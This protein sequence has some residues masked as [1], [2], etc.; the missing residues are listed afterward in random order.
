VVEDIASKAGFGLLR[1]WHNACLFKHPGCPSLSLFSPP[2]LPTRVIDV[3]P[4]ELPPE[5]RLY[6]AKAADRNCRYAI[7]SHCWGPDASNISKT[8][9]TNLEVLHDR[10][11]LST[12]SRNF[13]DAI[14]IAHGMK[15]RF[16][17][18]DA[19]CIIQDSPEDWARESAKMA[20]YYKNADITIA[21]LASPHASHGLLNPRYSDRNVA[22]I[23]TPCG[24][25]FVRPQL[26]DTVS[27]VSN[28]SYSV[29]RP[30]V[31]YM[32]LN[33]RAWT[34]Q[35]RVLSSRIIHFSEQQLV[36]Q[37]KTCA[38]SEDGQYTE[39][40]K[41]ASK[42]KL[43]DLLDLKINR[44]PTHPE[45]LISIIRTGWH[46]LLAEYTSPHLTYDSDKLPALSGLAHE[47]SKLTEDNY[48][49]GL[50][51][52]RL[53]EELLWRRLGDDDQR[54][55]IVPS[56]IHNG[57]PTWSWAS[58]KG[59]IR[60]EVVR[61][62]R[63][64]HEYD[65]RIVKTYSKLATSDPFG[66]VLSANVSISIMCHD[67]VGPTTFAKKSAHAAPSPPR[68]GS[69]SSAEDNTSTY[70]PSE[71]Q[72][73]TFATVRLDVNEPKCDFTATPHLIACFGEYNSDGGSTDPTWADPKNKHSHQEF[74][75]LQRKGKVAGTVYCRVG[76]AS[77]MDGTRRK[78]RIMEEEGWMRRTILIM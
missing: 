74:M 42:R 47:V 19:L 64:P 71:Y 2:E 20:Q 43:V 45:A 32:P 10:I 68:S 62:R 54:D 49:A 24:E 75:L 27:I 67:Y 61:Y 56:R 21:G 18:I 70:F 38:V 69:E 77:M 66:R 59:K 48:L 26:Y 6:T 8:C 60:N 3:G 78:L 17:W 15:I 57:S 40:S 12:L 16:L 35:E 25:V 52:R 58:L 34:V 41:T 22:R 72:D 50:W 11:D 9:L 13:S 46:D 65:P 1:Q 14:K 33:E 29:D 63:I 44:G 4:L 28:R 31:S 73:E 5:P 36:W 51:V 53:R 37:C 55:G 76:V 30:Y 23:S 7:L 39:H